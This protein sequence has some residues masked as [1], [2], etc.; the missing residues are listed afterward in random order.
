MSRGA[1]RRVCFQSAAKTDV[2]GADVRIARDNN[3]EI[4]ISYAAR[5]VSKG[6]EGDGQSNNANR[7]CVAAIIVTPH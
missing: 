1:T 2:I 3:L 6:G 5:Q 4:C 7:H